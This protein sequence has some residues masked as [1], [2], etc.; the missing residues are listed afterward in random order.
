MVATMLIAAAL[1]AFAARADSAGGSTI[2]HG[3]YA[4]C[5]SAQCRPLK[6]DKDHVVCRCEGPL[7][8]ANIGDSPCAVRDTNIISTFSL[9]DL[10]P[11]RGHAAKT[12]MHCA[13]SDM[14]RWASCLDAACRP[15]KGGVACTCKLQAISAFTVLGAGCPSDPDKLHALCAKIWSSATDDDFAAGYA[16]LKPLSAYA[17]KLAYCPVATK[18]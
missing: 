3:R 10:I 18:P 16:K 6:G 7:H 17:P 15:V 1:A 8:G 9:A 4:L 13:G 5:S 12:P 11:A 14:N 2:C